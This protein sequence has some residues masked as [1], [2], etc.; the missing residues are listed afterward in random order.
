[1]RIG[2]DARTV[3]GR[4]TG[5]STY[6]RG[7]I[8]GL[9]RL[10]EGDPI[11]YLD[12]RMSAPELNLSRSLRRKELNAPCGRI[13]SAWIFPKS[14]RRDGIDVAHV[15]YS[16]PP[17]MPCP[18]VT[19]IHDISFRR[20]PEFF[21]LKD[22]LILDLAVRRAGSHAARIIAVS[23]YTK[24][25]IVQIYGIPEDKIAVIHEAADAQYKPVDRFSA[26]SLLAEKYGIRSPFVL[27]VGVIQPRKNLGRLF[28]GFAQLKKLH[29]SERK[30]V[31]VGKHGWKESGYERKI[32]E[33]GIAD[34]VILT[35]YVPYAELPAFYSA[36]DLFVYPS[37]YEGFGLPPLEAM[38]CGTPVITGSQSS[39]PEVVGEAG[40]MVD[41]YD[42]HNFADAMANV[43]SAEKLRDEMSAR[44]LKQARKFSW[45]KMARET[46]EIY[47]SAAGLTED[48]PPSKPNP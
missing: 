9:S 19:T 45:D 8:E 47:R 40:V 21:S 16:I 27:T 35:G 26:Q 22:R 44:G 46:M 18:T 10:D 6:W 13:W 20:F 15:Q 28:E 29:D 34:D 39:L 42:P 30:L 7:L 25:E 38:A 14:L 37:L 41:P 43:L 36:A 2:I 32:S 31:V 17:R 4:F 12:G 23:E 3:Q 33:L 48:N 1:M 5:D 24:R 11:I